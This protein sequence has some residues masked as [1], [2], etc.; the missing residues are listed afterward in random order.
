[1]RIVKTLLAGAAICAAVLFA[2]LSPLPATACPFCSAPTLTLAEQYAK[3]DAAVLAKWLSGE[4]PG[5]ERLGSTTYEIVQVARTPLKSVE[6]GKKITLERIEPVSRETCRFC[7]EAGRRG[8]H[9]SG[10]HLWM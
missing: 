9:W 8:K 10:V 5:K 1:M 6:K 7:L 2:A 4:M 3:A